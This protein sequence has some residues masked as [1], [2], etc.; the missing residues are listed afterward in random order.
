M[1]LLE[2]GKKGKF[3]L[4]LEYSNKSTL[5][6]A[7]TFHEGL[8]LVMKND[9]CG[10]I[11]TKGEIVIPLQYQSGFYFEDG[12]CPVQKNGVWGYIDH[13]GNVKIP[14]IFLAASPFE[15]HRA[16]VYYNNNVHKIN[17]DGKCIKS[18]KDFPKW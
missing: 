3:I 14:F 11:N 2:K 8:A 6:D 17:P 12:L 7:Y 13:S 4:P 1:S 5:G 10:F 18:C 16:E 15:Y 9:S